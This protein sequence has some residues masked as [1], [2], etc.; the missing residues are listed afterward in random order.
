MGQNNPCQSRISLTC[1]GE[2]LIRLRG[3]GRYVCE[4]CQPFCN[5]GMLPGQNYFRSRASDMTSDP[6]QARGKPP[7]GMEYSTVV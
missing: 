1:T 4:M 2:G 6:N 5:D 7:Y 3:D